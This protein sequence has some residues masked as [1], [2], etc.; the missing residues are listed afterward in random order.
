MLNKLSQEIQLMLDLTITPDPYYKLIRS[1]KNRTFEDLLHHLSCVVANCERIV[2]Q[3]VPLSYA[4]HLSRFLSLFMYS[5]PLILIPSLG[6]LTV[7][8]MAVTFWAFVSI[9]EM[10]CFIEEPFNA[11]IQILP[12]GALISTLRS[13]ISGMYTI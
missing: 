6:W 11:E 1:N 10:A 12:L 8:T 7:P 9:Q 4:R 13:D 5:L 3:P 2:K